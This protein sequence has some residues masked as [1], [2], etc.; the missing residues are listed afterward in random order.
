MKCG[1]RDFGRYPL[2][3]RYNVDQVP[4]NLDN[5]CR[6]TFVQARSDTAVISGQP[7]GEKRFGTVQICV[8]GTGGEQPPL[9]LFFRGKGTVKRGEEEAYHPHV[10]VIFQEHAWADRATVRQWVDRVWVP[11]WSRLHP[12]GKSFLML[13]DHLSCQKSGG[14]VRALQASGGQLAFGPRN[15][16]E[17]WQPIDAGHLGAVLKAIAKQHFELWMEQISNPEDPVDQQLYNWQK[18][19]RNQ[20]CARDKRVLMTWIFGRSYEEFAGPK[21]LHCRQRAFR[22]TG[23]HLTTTG[24]NDAHVSI[25]NYKDFVPLPPGTPWHDHAYGNDSFTDQPAFA[26]ADELAGGDDEMGEETESSSTSTTD[27]EDSASEAPEEA[28]EAPE[29]PLPDDVVPP[30]LPPP[31]VFDFDWD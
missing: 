13:Q 29:V 15:K 21:Y 22:K 30:P 19:E 9:T 10:E 17:A 2:D 11:H 5:S 20:I 8:H 25:D 31:P 12:E 28:E 14:Y 4:F 26:F 1:R 6:R 16:T 23:M 27:S 18:W 3:C 24:R 7:G